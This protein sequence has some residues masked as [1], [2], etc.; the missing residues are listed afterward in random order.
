MCASP[1]AH[2]DSSSG[3]GRLSSAGSEA[4]GLNNNNN[5]CNTKLGDILRSRLSKFTKIEH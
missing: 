5:N 3:N 1:S 4:G 2:S